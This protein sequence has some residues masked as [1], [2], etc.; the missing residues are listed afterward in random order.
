VAQVQ[1]SPPI[2]AEARLGRPLH[3]IVPLA[4]SD[5]GKFVAFIDNSW[6]A[7][8]DKPMPIFVM[9]ERGQPL[10][11]EG[12]RPRTFCAA[13]LPDGK[14]LVSGGMDN[15]V[16]FW[17]V[18]SGKQLFSSPAYRGH[19]YALLVT[20][21]GKEMVVA[22]DGIRI[23]DVAA[24]RELRRFH[25]P[26]KDFHLSS[27]SDA[28]LSPDGKYVASY[29]SSRHVALWA[30]ENGK[31]LR[32]RAV[33]VGVVPGGDFYFTSDGS[34]ISFGISSRR[35]L[36]NVK[37]G[38]LA[39]GGLQ[40]FPHYQLKEPD[41][42]SECKFSRDGKTLA[43]GGTHGSLQLIDAEGKNA[44]RHLLDQVS[45]VQGLAW[46]ADGKTI[47]SS[48]ADNLAH[49]WTLA[50]RTEVSR[51]TQPMPKDSEYLPRTGGRVWILQKDHLA[52]WDIAAGKQLSVLE[53]TA[54]HQLYR[55]GIHGPVVGFS[56]SGT[57]IC[58]R[59]C[60][61]AGGVGLTVWDANTGRKKHFWTIETLVECVGV[62]DDGRTVCAHGRS[63]KD[64]ETI[65]IW[66]AT[67][68]KVRAELNTFL[69][70]G[71]SV[72]FRS[73]YPSPDGHTLAAAGE[74]Q[75]RPMR[76][77]DSPVVRDVIVWDLKSGKPLA[78]IPGRLP[79]AYSP[80]GRVLAYVDHD[81]TVNIFD[82]VTGRRA[83]AL[84]RHS[85]KVNGLTF[86]PDGRNLASCSEDAT[87]L[88]WDMASRFGKEKKK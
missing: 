62:S 56:P 73:L 58:A 77:R 74:Y 21:T 14:T 25:D 81:T 52:I 9:A 11:L 36:W 80:D 5:G 17:D 2:V 20:R 6:F 40:V 70:G 42:R 66:D 68:G 12:H 67:S 15:V 32:E 27:P 41:D 48:T 54:G 72:S 3:P 50:A 43:V 75:P 13:F 47:L 8:E 38:A 19:I 44:A 26:S 23:W 29:H 18:L 45:A 59:T 78:V 61:D 7:V 1:D 22:T 87:I 71:E 82:V 57:M 24:R 30:Y 28:A 84:P 86:S 69:L 65:T 60:L 88:V 51:K 76:G 79:L 85:A 83:R 49:E 34:E 37:T 35:Q 10:R 39:P 16:R 64:K 46:S 31:L 4:V 63:P 53:K 55:Q 33:Y